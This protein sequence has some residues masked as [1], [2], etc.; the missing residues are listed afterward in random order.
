M[1]NKYFDICYYILSIKYN[2]LLP[3][4]INKL[5]YFL[6]NIDMD[7]TLSCIYYIFINKNVNKKEGV[8]RF[9][10]K[11]LAACVIVCNKM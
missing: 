4:I 6:E 10:Y 7:F 5:P 3:M 2:F 11:I 1:K 8:L 9:L